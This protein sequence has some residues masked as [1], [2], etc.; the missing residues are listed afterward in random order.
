MVH[1]SDR[2]NV[3]FVI[4]W[5]NRKQKHKV[6]YREFRVHIGE[7]ENT[8]LHVNLMRLA[9][10]IKSQWF[11]YKFTEVFVFRKFDDQRNKY[12]MAI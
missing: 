3:Q 7:I 6:F 9:L 11:E 10:I 2:L 5:L 8:S 1:D 12:I 4:I